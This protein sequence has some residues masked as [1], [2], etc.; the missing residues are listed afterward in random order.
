MRVKVVADIL[1]VNDQQAL[2]NR[3]LFDR[4][5]VFVVNLISSPGAGKTSLLERTVAGLREELRL[6]VIE[7][8]IATTR[9]ADRVNRAGALAVQINTN[10]GCH[11][12]SQMVAR[13]L[14][15]FDLARLDLLFI[16]NV[17]NLV[18]P[19]EFALGEHARAVILSVTEGDDKPLKYPAVF[20]RA[21]VVLVNKI[22]L[23]PYTDCDLEKIHQEC[24]T[25][26]PR[27]ALFDLSCRTGEGLMAWHEWLR[28]RAGGPNG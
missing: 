3:E 24:R 25:L 26:N 23:L 16:E 6:A 1:A 4:H 8:D 15:G 28:A 10:G 5:G 9:D 20:Q 12:D 7:G 14:P 17:G 27:V 21:D 2:A 22:D 18:C 19:A 11:L 13:V